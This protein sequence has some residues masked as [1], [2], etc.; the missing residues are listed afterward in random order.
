[1]GKPPSNRLRVSDV[2][3]INLAEIPEFGAPETRLCPQCG[4]PCGR[5]LYYAPIEV[6]HRSLA[7]D[8]GLPACRKCHGLLYDSQFERRMKRARKNEKEPDA[9]PIGEYLD[10]LDH[11]L[12]APNRPTA[13]VLKKSWKGQF[14]EEEICNLL[15][16][17]GIDE[18]RNWAAP[19][20][21][22]IRVDD[23]TLRFRARQR[24]RIMEIERLLG[25]EV[26]DCRK[27]FARDRRV[28][29]QSYA[30]QTDIRRGVFVRALR[31][32]LNR[33]DQLQSVSGL[34]EAFISVKVSPNTLAQAERE[35]GLSRSELPQSTLLH[36]LLT[37]F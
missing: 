25:I 22:Y 36:D 20:V 7:R 11:L 28:G 27:M 15:D 3:Q 19:C 24:L 9:A 6:R 16:L 33:L 2:G 26:R 18:V 23:T 1:M 8:T 5:R 21:D 30:L 17:A 10:V 37:S 31:F 35:T 14:S 4:V 12:H 13:R 32:E 34:P 29:G